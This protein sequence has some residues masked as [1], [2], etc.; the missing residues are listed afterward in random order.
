MDRGEPLGT[1]GLV[2]GGRR[3]HVGGGT[4]C[5]GGG[6]WRRR[7]SGGGTVGLSGVEASV[8]QGKAGKGIRVA[9]DGLERWVHGRVELTGEEE[10]WRRNL[11]GDKAWQGFI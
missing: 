7:C 11:A 6:E 9:G 1:G 4:G 3:R 10:G 8:E 5:G 2:G